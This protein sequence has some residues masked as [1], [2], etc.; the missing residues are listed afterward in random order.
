MALIKCPD[1][2]KEYSNTSNSCPNCGFN[3]STNNEKPKINKKGFIIGAILLI[4]GLLLQF[5]RN[6]LAG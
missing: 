4:A 2:G 5:L 3:N 1:C 6:V